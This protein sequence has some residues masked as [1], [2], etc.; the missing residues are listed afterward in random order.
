MDHKPKLIAEER[1]PESFIPVAK[2][3]GH[4]IVK[5]EI[6]GEGEYRRPE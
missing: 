4:S 1:I 2:Q 5:V 3:I 6:S